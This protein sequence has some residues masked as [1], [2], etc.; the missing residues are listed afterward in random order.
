M[1]NWLSKTAPCWRLGLQN[2]DV[3]K[4]EEGARHERKQSVRPNAAGGEGFARD[5]VARRS[6]YRWYWN[7]CRPGS[8][9]WRD[10]RNPPRIS[11]MCLHKRGN[12]GHK[13]A[14][15]CLRARDRSMRVDAPHRYE[16]AVASR[17]RRRLPLSKAGGTRPGLIGTLA[18]GTEP[19]VQYRTIPRMRRSAW[20]FVHCD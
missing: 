19:L 9:C 1:K 20:I 13:M 12:R 8:D 2:P 3:V 15:A 7:G 11:S 16:P 14:Q 10:T 6:R 4:I 18:A 5:P 17:G